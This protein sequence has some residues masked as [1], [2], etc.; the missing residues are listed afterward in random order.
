MISAPRDARK[1]E[2]ELLPFDEYDHVIV[3]FSGGKDSTA[4]VLHLLEAGI[5]KERIELWHQAV[6][7]RPGVDQRFF[8]WPVTEAYC[9]AFAYA[10]GMKIFFQWKEGGFEGEML[11]KDEPTKPTTFEL[12]DGSLETV[13]GKGPQGTRQQ[14]PQ[15]SADLSTRWCS[16][17]LKIDVAKKVFS[18]D[19]RFDNT[20]TLFIT[21]ER[22]QESANR[23]RYAEVVIHQSSTRSRRIDQWRAILGY[24][25]KEVWDIMRRWRIQPHPAYFTG[26]GRVSCFACIFGNPNQWAAVRQLNPELFGKIAAYEKA[27]GKTIKRKESI[28]VQADKGQSF[29]P[30]D[31]ELIAVAMGEEF[32]PEWIITPEGE[33]WKMPLGAFKETGG[34]V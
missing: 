33:K 34:P 24:S 26:F 16:A 29:V 11:R 1:N 31:P 8:D 32:R 15:V 21:G 13:G 6:D 20:K 28:E 23:S 25:E 18:N 5:P 10:M 9:R 27:F 7:G 22:R 17:Y 12:E 2:I 3:S 19:P 4:C 14:F 30:D